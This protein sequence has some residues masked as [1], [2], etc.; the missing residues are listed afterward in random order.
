MLGR[1]ILINSPAKEYVQELDAP[2][3]SKDRNVILQG[4]IQ[5][6]PFH[7]VTL[8]VTLSAFRDRLFSIQCRVDIMSN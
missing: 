5:Y 3:Y 1:Q 2:A 7:S 6:D 4:Q 8:G